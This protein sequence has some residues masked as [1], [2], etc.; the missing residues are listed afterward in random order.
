M[1]GRDLYEK[2]VACEKAGDVSGAFEAYRRSAKASPRVAAPYVGLARILSDN[3]Q[4]GEAIACLHRA[5]ACEPESAKIRILLGRML[6]QDGRLDEARE[7]FAH[8]LRLDEQ[9]EGAA[10]GLAGIFEYLGDRMAAAGIYRHLLDAVPCHAEA[11]AGLLGVAEG[12]ALEAALTTAHECLRM[13]SDADAALIGYALGKALAGLHR[14]D[15]AFAA[16]AA[17]NAAR[18]REAGAFD[19]AGFDAR[20]DRLIGIFSKDFFAARRGW[21]DSSARPVFIVGLPRSGTTLTEQVLA[22]HAQ[23]HGAGELDLLTDMATGTPDRLGR[24]DPAWPETA[25]ELE[26]HHIAA[27]AHDHLERLDALAPAEALR[28]ID[29]QPLNF[30]HL[31]LVM[32][33]FP[34][35]RIIHCRRDIR[36]NGLSIFAEDFT[37]EQRW[38]T[39]LGDIV[40]YWRG[41]R[42]LM[43]HWAAAGD[44]RLIDMRY[45]DLVRDLEGQSRHLLDFLG[46]DWDRSV[47]HFHEKDR[48]VQTPSRWQVRKPLYNSSSGR[49][50]AYEGQLGPLIAAADDHG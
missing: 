44:L 23:I 20:I 25:P 43:D 30:W 50:R 7:Q 3:H 34:N 26:L 22:G 11:L 24:P 40:H 31:G 47:L 39:D 29:K 48:A 38:A 32:L 36:D 18:R 35:A 28:V 6:T 37:P 33:A 45:E 15:E 27:I 14:H 46:L 9:A 19:R 21:G 4:R 12:D 10:V 42:R 1:A 2:G 49:W 41:Y 16:W 5:V 8:A 13:A 17:A